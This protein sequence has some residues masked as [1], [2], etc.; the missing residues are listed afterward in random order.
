[1]NCLR[2]ICN[3]REDL[4]DS[5]SL[6]LWRRMEVVPVGL[7]LEMT[8][9]MM[10]SMLEKIKSGDHCYHHMCL[11]LED[12][13]LMLSRQLF[14][15]SFFVSYHCSQRYI[16]IQCLSLS[17]MVIFNGG[18]NLNLLFRAIFRA[19]SEGRLPIS[20]QDDSS[21]IPRSMHTTIL[22]NPT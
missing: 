5:S 2:R 15:F 4:V 10:I 12:L 9:V 19:H 6:M 3:K 16:N 22:Y 8:A 21:T 20:L 14:F 17:R 7:L 11:V 18:H 13:H 1:M